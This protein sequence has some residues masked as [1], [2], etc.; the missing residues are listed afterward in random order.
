M[1]RLN[2]ATMAPL[3]ETPYFRP[4]LIG[5]RFDVSQWISQRALQWRNGQH[6]SCLAQTRDENCGASNSHGPAPAS[7]G[8]CG[9]HAAQRGPLHR[10]L[11]QPLRL[12]LFD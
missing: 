7:L 4:R 10:G 2:M 12:H 9:D 11:D 1:A 5:T 3:P 8:Q 6:E